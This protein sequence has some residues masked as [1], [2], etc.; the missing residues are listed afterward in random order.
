LSKLLT[1]LQAA[2]IILLILVAVIAVAI[3]FYAAP[4]QKP[5]PTATPTTPAST[6]PA[7]GTPSPTEVTTTP[8]TQP[9]TLPPETTAPPE[10]LFPW[11]KQLAELATERDVTLVIL[12]RHEQSIQSKTIQK[13]LQSPVAQVLGIRNLQFVSAPAELW[14]SYI[15]QAAKLGK[16]I[17]VAW[18]GGPTLFN[19][20]DA[21]GYLLP[22]NPNETVFQPIV[23][24]LSKI[25]K[26][27]AGAETYKVD[28]NGYIR[29]IG[30]SVSSFG[31]TVNH[32]RLQQYGLPKPSKWEDLASPEYAIYLPDIPMISIAD[33]TM[34]TSNLRIFE[35]ILQAKGWE[36]GWRILT[37][38]AANAVIYQSSSDARDAVIRGDTAIGTTI[39]FYGYMAQQTNPNCEYIAPEGET[40]IN[41]D[42]IAI[43]KGTKHL[44]H[45]VA[46]VAWVLNEYGGQQVWLDPDINRLPVNSKVF[47]TPLGKQR[48][49]LYQ[50]LQKA[51]NTRGIEF[52]ETLS[53]KWVNSVMY[54]FKA[55][56]VNPHDDLQ[57]AWS[58]IAQA[59]LNGEISR[60]WFD[61][62]T[63]Y[64][65]RPLTFT[66]PVTGRQVTF[67]IDYAIFINEKLKDSQIYQALMSQWEQ[68]ARERYRS[69]LD[70]LARAK[71]GE[72][73]PSQ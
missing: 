12:T 36:E 21:E 41:S 18:G 19:T 44:V 10:E 9:S 38:L 34:S 70:L 29:W 32:V 42:P 64:I 39:D 51:M 16:P 62:L 46:F 50:A 67:T 68:L 11:L 52:N 73:V 47:D 27:I 60:E 43:V 28:E 30:A 54:Y 49:D 40:I 24:E 57:Y 26:T 37:L 7:T 1:T 65:S 15:E 45:A 61:Y 35:I 72:P 13:F 4:P 31:F 8:A 22:I 6:S 23:Y 53:T 63:R 33:P 59:Y 71:A 66:D 5:T 48:Q 20:L 3:Y 69:A 58:Q 55:T 56:L 14:P 2:L 25:P 17:D